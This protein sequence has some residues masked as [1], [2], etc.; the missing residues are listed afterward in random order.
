MEKKKQLLFTITT[1]C[2]FLVGFLAVLLA[3]KSNLINSAFGDDDPFVMDLDRGV[4]S[5]ELSSGEA[6]FDTANGNDVTFKFSSASAGDV[7]TL[8]TGGN[9]YNHTKITGIKKIE[10]TL[11]GGS[12]TLSYGNAMDVLNVGS[13]VLDTESGSNV[14][15]TVNFVEPSDYFKLSGVTGP[16]EI[17]GL[18]IT[19]SCS[20]DYQYA[21]DREVASKDLLYTS[22][23]TDNKIDGT[24]ISLN[25]R[26]FDTSDSSSGYSYKI[27]SGAESDSKYPNVQL[28]FTKNYD[29]SHSGLTIK[30]KFTADGTTTKKWMS[31]F[32][33]R[34]T[35]WTQITNEY[36]INF[37]GSDGEWLTATVSNA[38]LVGQLKDGFD[39]TAV[40]LI[41]LNFNLKNG[42]G[43][44]QNI[45]L[46]ELHFVEAP[47][48]QE[49][50]EMVEMDAGMTT[51]TTS[52][53][54][55]SDIYGSNSTSARKFTFE[56]TNLANV[57]PAWGRPRVTFSPDAS[58][59][60]N[61]DL[62]NT[63]MSFDIK[64]SQE[65]FDSEDNQKHTFVLKMYAGW[66]SSQQNLNVYNFFPNG[67]AGF[68]PENTD[69]GWIHLE[70]NM[71]IS[72][73]SGFHSLIR[74]EFQFF[75]LNDTTKTTAWVVIDNITFTPNA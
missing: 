29:L 72:I 62:C 53:V 70:Q 52:N 66:E 26:C 49:S 36:G 64:L 4:T 27:S 39:L 14:P 9:F 33:Y 16:M 68:Y 40:G 38:T 59:L 19:Y 18:R 58:G 71:D 12:A 57:S 56:D 51:A 69:N 6:I 7:L 73:Y 42:L 61:I 47:T 34:G 10:A 20:N 17:N 45:W 21:I 54:T 48:L 32:L 74:M 13:Q 41:R 22:S 28:G 75:G 23:I 46:D 25:T 43:H 30:A 67:A 24:H 63:T 1:S 2:A 11:S 31:I 5:G 3:P 44:E 8:A 55:Y 35:D 65:F 60:S 37:S 15:F 50:I